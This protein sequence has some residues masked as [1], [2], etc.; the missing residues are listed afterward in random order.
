V[1]VLVAVAFLQVGRLVVER[2][3]VEAEK[4]VV[5]AF[6]NKCSDKES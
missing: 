4:K 5:E 2:W 3:K 6:G 1:G